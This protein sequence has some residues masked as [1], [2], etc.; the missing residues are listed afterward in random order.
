MKIALVTG[1]RAE[2]GLL[3]PFAKLIWMDEDTELQLLVTGSHLSRAH[4]YTIDQISLPVSGEIECVLASDTETGVCKGI[5][6]AVAGFSDTF[7]RLNPDVVILLGD[8]WEILA[9]AIAAHIHRIPVGHIH[10]GEITAGAIDDAW[11]HSITK[12]SQLHF[13]AT[14]TYRKRVIQ[15]GEHPDTVFNVGALG[16]QGLERRYEQPKNGQVIVLYHS[17]TLHP[18]SIV[19]FR[20]LVKA[21]DDRYELLPI[22][23]KPNADYKSSTVNDIVD[24]KAL[25]WP[26]FLSLHREDFLKRL[27]NSDAIIGNSSSGIIEAPAL[28]VPTINIG[29][30]QEGRLRASSIIDVPEPTMGNIEKAFDTLYSKEFQAGLSDIKAPYGK[31]ENVAGKILDI[32]KERA[33]NIDMMKGFYDVS[34]T[35]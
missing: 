24:E 27:S 29:R 22:F 14:E 26:V 32:I 35:I 6:L 5:S 11:R 4:G 20:N 10:G 28:G 1:S 23:I 9:A 12:M 30:R 8:R 19:D 21:I 17:E 13:T 31:G 33:G 7:E 18:N 3:E 25:Y 15:L 16:T 2:W 34:F